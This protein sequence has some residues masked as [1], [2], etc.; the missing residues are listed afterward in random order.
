MMRQF[1]NDKYHETGKVYGSIY[2]MSVDDHKIVRPIVTADHAIS[3]I[4]GWVMM[5]T[6]AENAGLNLWEFTWSNVT[7][8]YPPLSDVLLFN[9]PYYE[10]S[11]ENHIGE[12]PYVCISYSFTVYLLL[13]VSLVLACF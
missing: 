7:S 6:L 13:Y 9:L 2:T 4:S 1:S 12:L 3:T 8:K 10:G 5:S 11:V